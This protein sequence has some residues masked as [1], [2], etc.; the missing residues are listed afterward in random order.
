MGD[1][2]AALRDY[3]MANELG[4][5]G[6]PGHAVLLAESGDADGA[7][8]ALDRVLVNTDWY[9]LQRKAMLLGHKARILA[10]AG[11]GE[12]ART[13]IAEM[14]DRYETW[15]SKAVHALA[16]ETEALL[17]SSAEEPPR[18]IQLLHLARQLW[19]SAE[20]EYQAARVRIHLAR[21]MQNSGDMAGAQ[22]EA[23]CAEVAARKI[24]ARKILDDAVQML[25]APHAAKSAATI[26]FVK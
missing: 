13:V 11:R 17:L 10:A 3:Q 24:G 25:C 9:A 14:H 8:A 22:V 6:Q 12:Q 1:E 21:I 23:R 4:G 18:A 7:I 20:A 5:D 26:S 19:S 2:A 16:L 15:P